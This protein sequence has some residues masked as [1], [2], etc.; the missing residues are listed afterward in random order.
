M[1]EGQFQQKSYA[2]QGRPRLRMTGQPETRLA[3]LV[4]ERGAREAVQRI[5]CQTRS[6]KAAPSP[7]SGSSSNPVMHDGR[8]GG[9]VLGAAHL[10]CLLG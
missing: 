9:G 2:G 10:L 6:Y 8:N 3:K 1:G 4:R 7:P 5:L